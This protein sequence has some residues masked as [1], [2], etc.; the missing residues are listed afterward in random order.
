MTAA[1]AHKIAQDVN[2]AANNSQYD[3]VI[4]M[5]KEAVSKGKFEAQVHNIPILP[6][7]QLKLTFNGYKVDFN[8]ERNESY[9]TITW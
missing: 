2:I 1:E 6:D 9:T 4:A 3:D 7:V 8:T 5:I